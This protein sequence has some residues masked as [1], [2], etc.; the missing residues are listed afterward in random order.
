M[1]KQP[2]IEIKDY[3]GRFAKVIFA[4]IDISSCVMN[5]SYRPTTV[6]NKANFTVELDIRS[7]VDLLSETKDEDLRTAREI[8][9]RHREIEG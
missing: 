2:I 4:G 5:V 3:E 1:E 6:Y 8:I 7:V 9:R